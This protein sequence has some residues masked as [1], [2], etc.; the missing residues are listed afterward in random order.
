[1][2]DKRSKQIS[3]AWTLER[4]G[5]TAWLEELYVVPERRECGIGSL[6]LGAVLERVREHG[7]AAIDL[8]VDI[9]HDR[10]T[11]LYMREGFE[12]LNRS[13]WAKFL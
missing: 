10:A 8:E 7:C 3:I 11:H 12:Q 6:M 2:R 4:G 5:L 1:M 13:R 9:T